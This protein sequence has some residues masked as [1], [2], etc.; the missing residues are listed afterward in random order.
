[1]KWGVGRSKLDASEL[2]TECVRTAGDGDT[3]VMLPFPV[4]VVRAWLHDSEDIEDAAT[5]LG[6]AKVG[7]LSPSAQLHDG[8]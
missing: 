3:C 6:L 2:L 7:F 8:R 4:Y 1:M 5:L